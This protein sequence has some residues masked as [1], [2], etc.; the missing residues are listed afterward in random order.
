MSNFAPFFIAL[1]ILVILKFKL[2]REVEIV[3]WPQRICAFLLGPTIIYSIYLLS[4]FVEAI[5]D[6]GAA[7]AGLFLILYLLVVTPIFAIIMIISKVTTIIKI[8]VI[9][10][11]SQIIFVLGVFGFADI[12][13]Q[14]IAFVEIEI[15]SVFAVLTIIFATSY[16]AYIKNWPPIDIQSKIGG[17]E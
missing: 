7:Y 17:N 2:W 10:L 5:V 15:L 11:I 12:P 16:W 4:I 9:A 6:N 8:F 13:A 1:A 3:H 14:A